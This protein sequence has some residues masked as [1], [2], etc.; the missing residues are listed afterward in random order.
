MPPSSTRSPRHDR[1]EIA[2]LLEERRAA[3]ADGESER[4]F[5]REAPIARSTLRD[6]V[7]RWQQTQADAETVAFFASPTGQMLLRRWVLAA[8]FVMTLLGCCGIHTV[9]SFLVLAGLGPFVGTSF[10]AQQKINAWMHRHVASF[11]TEETKR[12]GATMPHK[13]IW[14]CED[15]TFFEQMVLVAIEAR[16]GFVLVEQV[17]EARDAVTW[18]AVLDEALATLPVE[19][20]GVTADGASGIAAHARQAFGLEVT[21]D[22]FHV[23]HDV[24]QS[25]VGALAQQVRQASEARDEQAT[26]GGDPTAVE[27][28]LA[29]VQQHQQQVQAAIEGISEAYRPYDDRTGEIRRGGQVRAELEEML[30][31]VEVV[32][33]EAAL[34]ETA[35]QGVG[36]ARRAVEAMVASIEGYHQRIEQ[37]LTALQLPAAIEA[38][39][40]T[41]LLPALY[42]QKVAGQSRDSVTK[43]RLE[44]RAQDLVAPLQQATSPMKALSEAA[45]ADLEQQGREWVELY[46]RSSSRVEGRNGQLELHHHSAHGLSETKLAALTAVHNFWVQRPEGTTAAERLFEQKPR[47][48]FEQ[49]LDLLPDLPRAAQKRPHVAPSLLLN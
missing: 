17:A 13:K 45:I 32:A 38:A 35:F 26:K 24:S 31:L 3:L 46:E 20:V 18:N 10:G 48:L 16:S 6:E 12:L 30:D 2:S 29:E 7:E 1:L 25:T 41:Q 37:N 9:C 28:R 21:P 23:V 22:G 39:M 5:F 34:S 49:M 15:E 43:A 36:K 40:G 19:V 47:D 42:L 44:Q 11:A 33:A 8:H 14:L 4:Q 27:E